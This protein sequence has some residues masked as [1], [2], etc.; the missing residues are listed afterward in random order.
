MARFFLAV[1][2]VGWACWGQFVPQQFIVEMSEERTGELA[3]RLARVRARQQG[4]ERNL[5]ARGFRT[6]EKV[7]RVANALLV[8]ADGD[9]TVAM[10]TLQSLPGVV[11]VSRVRLF[12]KSLDR[13]A[14]LHGAAEVWQRSGIEKAGAR[15]KVGI[16][17]SG[18]EVKH[19]GFQDETLPRL[20][21][22][23]KVNDERDLVHTN[24]KVIVA[25]SYVSL[26]SRP[27]P[28]PSALDKDG[29]GTAV[30]MAAVGAR[31]TAP[32]GEIA[33]MAPAAYLG[34]YKVF[35]TTGVNDSATDAAILKAIE[36]SVND[37]MDVINLSLGSS[38]VQRTEDDVIVRALERAVEAG[39]IVVVAAGN[40]GPGPLTVESPGIAPSAITVGAN[41]N[42]RFFASALLVNGS[43]LTAQLGSNTPA[44]GS[45]EGQLVDVETV[46]ASSL[47]CDALP[48][49]TLSGR[50]VL[51]QR[52]TCTFEVKNLN[53][54]RAG[55]KG[56]V[57]YSDAARP[58]DF[59]IPDTGS[60]PLPTMFLRRSDGLAVRSILAGTESLD[61][62]LDFSRSA[63]EQNFRRVASF[64]S[65]GPLPLALIK[66]DLLAVGTMFYTAAQTN[67]SGGDVY[68][69]S[70][71]AVIQ[72]TSFSSPVVAGLA[73]SLKSL[74]PGL[75][76]ADYR[77]L[78]IGSARALDDEAKSP[79]STAGS[80]LADLA[81]AIDTP[82]RLLPPSVAF[83]SREQRI[84]VSN[85]GAEA[86]EYSVAVEA[87]TGTAPTV[88]ENKIQLEPGA[89][90]TL[91]LS[92]DLETLDAGVYAGTLVLRREG[93][94]V[95][96]TPYFF[97]KA[98]P[99][100]AVAIQPLLSPTRARS[101]VAQRNLIFFRV[102]DASGLVIQQTP[103][104]R[105]VIGLGEVLAVEWRDADVVGAY[106]LDLVL[107][108]GTNVIEVD[109]GNGVTRRFTILGQ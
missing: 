11:R 49:G 63:R 66:P 79:V 70:G 96:R 74:R 50:L 102:V 10:A 98:N 69:P 39:V 90:A 73:A 24:R 35:G 88:N 25:R 37:G 80:G 76:P 27:D 40:S 84:E 2:L 87:Q 95:S 56:L 34:V 60:A 58:D 99:A 5:T 12:Q 47:A 4:L 26:L 105:V 36:D 30:A 104:A 29:H 51:V 14:I 81:R 23:P 13:A 107:S 32:N 59:I 61:V 75:K 92:L 103:K 22:Y 19:P 15:M 65:R 9:D 85:L 53:V 43:T 1:F 46:D 101:G 109:A 106:G 68:S 18:I 8:E 48:S 3:E 38:L 54:A 82:L 67:F 89:A 94:V 42:G 97:G 41:E 55:A 78:L 71:Y 45:L 6:K 83:T 108:P 7:S 16:I 17:D 21:G 91:R 77:S 52:G 57:L 72:G 62:K 20:E 33:G 93:L 28:E 100:G 44:S 86:A 31:H 64:S